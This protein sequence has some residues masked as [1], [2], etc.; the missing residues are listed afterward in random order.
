[1]GGAWAAVGCGTLLAA[2]VLVGGL[3]LGVPVTSW[4]F[5]VCLAV[6]FLAPAVTG[7][8]AYRGQPREAEFTAAG[9]RLRKG[10]STRWLDADDLVKVIVT[11]TG[12]PGERSGTT[13][14]LLPRGEQPLMI[15]GH[16]DTR[17]P[18]AL[19]A[20]LGPKVR[21]EWRVR[22]DPRDGTSSDDDGNGDAGGGGDDADGD[23]GDA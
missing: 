5:P 22:P 23:G 19:T 18:D 9:V 16:R 15:P 14:Y 8:R 7:A 17:V 10:W 1:M 3:L 4:W 11:H 12:G 6:P 20:L 21:E 2:P 13:L